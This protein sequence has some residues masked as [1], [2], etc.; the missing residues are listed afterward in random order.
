[1]TEESSRTC[2]ICVQ[3]TLNAVPIINDVDANQDELKE[4]S[5]STP[6]GS[7]VAKHFWF[8]VTES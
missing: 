5:E 6:R 2:F 7:V 3:E 8:E 1:M 4:L